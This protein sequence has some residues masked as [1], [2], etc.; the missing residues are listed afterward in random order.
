MRSR[1]GCPRRVPSCPQ[2]E[3]TAAAL[4]KTG[5]EVLAG[6]CFRG[7]LGDGADWWMIGI[8]DD[9]RENPFYKTMQKNEKKLTR[10]FRV[11]CCG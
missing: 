6:T 4:G 2:P 3:P 9:G 7:G 5:R 11:G 1:G 10:R 8:R